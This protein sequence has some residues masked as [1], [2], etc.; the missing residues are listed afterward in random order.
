MNSRR[1]FTI[2]LILSGLGI[3]VLF[4]DAQDKK[5]LPRIG[6]LFTGTAASNKDRLA[7]L[8][9]GLRER[10]FID[11]KTATITVR[12]ADGLLERLQA[13][14]T[15]LVRDK[16]DVVIAA[17][18]TGTE[19]LRR[20]APAI[21]IV[22][23]SCGD[24]IGSG[25]AASL[26]RPGYNITGTTIIAPELTLKRIQLLREIVPKLQRMAYLTAPDISRTAALQDREVDELGEKLGITTRAFLHQV[27]R[28]LEQLET[29]LGTWRP[30]GILVMDR[31]GNVQQR[32]ELADLAVRLRVPLVAGGGGFAEAGALV[33]YGAYYDANYRRAAYFVDRILKGTKPADLPIEQPTKFEL[34]INKRTAKA[35]GVTVPQTILVWTDRFIE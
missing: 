35:L 12:Y 18:G 20:V 33:G 25:F 3:P 13:H 14:A 21:P 15:E 5:R 31:P 8:F 17:S 23:V 4:A 2:A 16:P 1:R 27:G 9:E 34:V 29:E 26:A 19:A 6:V 24:Y 10:G 11:G 28:S 22:C 7:P 30:D 32:K